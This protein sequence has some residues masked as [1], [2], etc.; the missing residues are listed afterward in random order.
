MSRNA[1]SHEPLH[2]PRKTSLSNP[3]SQ[4]SRRQYKDLSK[5][6]VGDGDIQTE[7]AVND[8]GRVD[9]RIDHCS[10]YLRDHVLP[11]IQCPKAQTKRFQAGQPT[12]PPSITRGRDGLPPPRMNIAIHVVGSR[13]DV[14]PFV[15]LGQVLREKYGHRVRLATHPNFKS[16][17]EENGLEFFSIGEDPAELMAFMVKNPGLLPNIG[18]LKS[19]DIGRRRRGMYEVMKGCWRS[20]IETGNGMEDVDYS[21]IFTGPSEHLDR[22]FIADAIIANPPSFAHVHCA[23]RLGIPLH[24]MFT[25]PWSPTQS[26]PHPLSTIHHSNT[27]PSMANLISYALVDIMTWQG[28]G[29][30]VNRFRTKTLHLEPV[31]LMWAPGM[32]SRL[33]I[34]F[35][36]CWSP[37]L[38]PK[39]EDWGSHIFLSGFYFLSLGSSYD[40][41]TKLRA[42]LESGHPPVY[43]GFGSIVV[44]EPDVMTKI[45]FEATKKAGV[46]ALVSKGWG[47]LG[48]D[49]LDIPNNICMIGDVPHDWLFKH[50]SAV[51]HHGGAG[52]TAAGILAGCPTVVIPFFGDQPFWGAMIERAGAGPAP[53]PYKKLTADA[54]AAGIL[55]AIEPGTVENAKKLS[56]ALLK[57]Q[58]AITGAKSFH[59]MLDLD[60]Q[61][62]LVCPKRVAVARVRR[63]NIRLSAL[64]TIVLG[65]EGL[66]K[67]SDL[68]M[69]RPCEYNTGAE[70]WDPVTGG[71]AALLGTISSLMIGMAD[72]P[73]EIINKLKSR[74]HN[75]HEDRASRF[76]STTSNP[77]ADL[78]VANQRTE[79]AS[80]KN[81]RLTETSTIHATDPY[82]SGSNSSHHEERDNEQ[83]LVDPEPVTH[84]ITICSIVKPRHKHLMNPRDRAVYKAVE[85]GDQG[86][87]NVAITVMRPPMD[88]ILAVSRGCHNAPKQYG[89]DT[90]R[91]LDDVN[92]FKSG[93]VTAGK[94]FGLGWYDGIAGVVTQPYRGG[95][96]HGAKGFLAG[97]LKGAGGL[98]LKPSIFGLGGYTLQGIYREIQEHMGEQMHRYAVAAR[99]TQGHEDWETSTPEER[100]H[101]IDNYNMIKNDP[102]LKKREHLF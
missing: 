98:I 102:L 71:A 57:D 54:L 5:L 32:I 7:A 52:T 38:I 48:T 55:K 76:Q 36:Y 100:R 4:A 40:P 83:H 69:Y 24:L 68:K 20:C 75:S 44:D 99:I 1:A 77:G 22:P 87:S 61:R 3:L 15:S 27:E 81:T 9:I 12:L 16:F 30:V 18:T 96:E 28:L 74:V 51:V 66:L 64:A 59:N 88:L 56:E 19:G 85:M 23:E 21:R 86:I 17:V 73:F 82:R 41:D 47:G 101:I 78:G 33:R 39:P 79:Q 43:V 45:I 72:V 90:V 2:P 89:D 91:Q 84:N 58:G 63:T 62:C 94:Q 37:A 53:V 42:F 31:S 8:D 35:T 34:P 95:V 46:R 10:E 80:S 50:V 29:G 26:F 60:N 93:V 11:I 13:G 25:M 70:P 49:E 6:L 67:A 14:Q 65:D 92:D 97:I